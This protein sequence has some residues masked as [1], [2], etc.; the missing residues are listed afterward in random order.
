MVSPLFDEALFI[1]S[2]L[3]SYIQAQW[4]IERCP[5][6]QNSAL[7]CFVEILCRS[8]TETSQDQSLNANRDSVTDFTW[9][10]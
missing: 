2:V 10:L 3:T 1:S 6:L 9:T 5:I 8:N 4:G 7:K